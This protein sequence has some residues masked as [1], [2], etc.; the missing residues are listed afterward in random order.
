[1]Q[2]E[3]QMT[4]HRLAENVD[5]K[6]IGRPVRPLQERAPEDEAIGANCG[7]RVGLQI[8]LQV[9]DGRIV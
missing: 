2:S 4:P 7:K 8:E 3:N 6:E 9:V 5:V 1:M